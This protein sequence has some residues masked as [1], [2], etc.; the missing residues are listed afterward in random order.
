[1]RKLILALVIILCFTEHLLASDSVKVSEPNP[2]RLAVS[3]GITAG[4]FVYAYGIQNNIWWK[5]EK[6]SFHFNNKDDWGYALG[7]DK[8]GHFYFGY[9]I[10][11]IYSQVF[12]WIGYNKQDSKLY[13]AFLT[14]VYQTFLEVRDGFSKNYGFSWGDF[15]ANLLGTSFHL[16]EDQYTFL[17][18][19][20]FKISYY[21]SERFQNNSNEYI[22]DDYEST[23]NWISLAVNDL[24]PN[25]FEKVV[26]E[27]LNFAIGHSVK[28]LNSGGNHE[29]FL[30]LDWNLNKLPLQGRFW[31]FLKR[32]LNHYHLPAPAVKIY[33]NVVWYG[34]KF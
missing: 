11:D 32:N 34:L 33:P 14:T 4:A 7:S 13:A 28:N 25:S 12:H 15:S 20:D 16:L 18:R 8:Y 30:S 1:M 19:F 10:S 3:G 22:I 24:L 9:L 29:L 2:V 5:G 21:P 23:Y 31:N 27:Y 6:G 26:P 17:R